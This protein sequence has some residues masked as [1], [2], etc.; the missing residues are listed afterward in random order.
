MQILKKFNQ[1]PFELKA[2]AIFS[3]LITL[4]SFVLPAVLAKHGFFKVYKFRFF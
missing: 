3:I 2:F 4:L 1:A